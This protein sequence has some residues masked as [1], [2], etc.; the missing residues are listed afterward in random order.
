MGKEEGLMVKCSKCGAEHQLEGV[1]CSNCSV[2]VVKEQRE[3]LQAAHRSRVRLMVGIV[4]GVLLT[5][6]GAA[7]ALFGADMG[8]SGSQGLG[9]GLLVVG[10]IVLFASVV[11]FGWM[12]K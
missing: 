1:Y 11:L 2:P 8:M 9:Y 3:S 10:I 12:R 4:A 7:I 5:G 6:I